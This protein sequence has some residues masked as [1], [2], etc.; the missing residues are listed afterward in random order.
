MCDKD[1]GTELDAVTRRLASLEEQLG[2]LDKRTTPN[3]LAKA[4]DSSYLS[5]NNLRAFLQILSLVMT[6]FLAGA[7]SLGYLGIQNI[8]KIQEEARKTELIRQSAQE[9]LTH[10]TE[11]GDQIGAKVTKVDEAIPSMNTRIEEQVQKVRQRTDEQVDRVAQQ[12][13]LV[14]SQLRT[15]A[16]VF[17]KVALENASEL[18]P[19][20]QQMLVLL[21]REIDPKNPALNFNAAWWAENF[22]RYDDVL[23]LVKTVLDTRDLPENIRGQAVALQE[24]ARAAKAKPP[25]LHYQ[26]PE[27]AFA[28]DFGIVALPI[29]ILNELIFSGHLTLAQ[30]QQVIDKSRRRPQ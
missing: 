5:I 15:I 6:V 1:Q 21:A 30:A 8:Q 9:I 29:N 20:E 12:V 22:R 4:I 11:A 7:I 10:V 13:S 18:S 2:R 19:R 27:G 17:N 26:E 28:G 25:T 14:E 23:K 24:R 16:Q 3:E